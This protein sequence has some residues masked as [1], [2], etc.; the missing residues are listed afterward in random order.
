M[1]WLPYQ[2]ATG[3]V[4]IIQEELLVGSSAVGDALTT[5]TVR[6]AVD[7]KVQQTSR[8]LHKYVGVAKARRNNSGGNQGSNPWSDVELADQYHQGQ[9]GFFSQVNGNAMSNPNG[10]V[11]VTYYIW[12]KG[13]RTDIADA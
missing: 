13:Q 9:T 7:F 2:F 11:Y 5:T 6:L 8:N 12:F 1:T 4:N 10:I 3:T